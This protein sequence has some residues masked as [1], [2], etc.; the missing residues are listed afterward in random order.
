VKLRNVFVAACACALATFVPH[1]ARAQTPVTFSGAAALALPIGDLGNAADVGFNLALRGEGKIGSPG[2]SLRGDLSYDRFGGKG[3]V[4]SYSYL[5]VAANLVHRTGAGRLYEFGG[6]GI[7]GSKTSFENQLD[8]D[9]TNL[10]VQMGLG[11]DLNPGPHTPF[12][13]FGLTSVF[14]SGSNSLW[15]PVRFGVRF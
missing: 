5:G 10:G 11:L 8:H 1:V 12:V 7:Y 14:T 2:W 4:D 15:F 9:D 3:V 6:L 13:E